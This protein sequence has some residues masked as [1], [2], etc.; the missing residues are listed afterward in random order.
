MAVAHKIMDHDVS[1]EARGRADSLRLRDAA[2]M[3]NRAAGNT[4]DGADA[5]MI[6]RIFL[7]ASERGVRVTPD[8]L[9]AEI[10]ARG[11]SPHKAAELVK[12][13]LR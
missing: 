7:A 11:R 1:E 8:Y 2:F 5:E 4:L 10:K 12:A 13:I 9:T 3:I 6:A